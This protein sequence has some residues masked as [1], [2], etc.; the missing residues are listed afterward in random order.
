MLLLRGELCKGQRSLSSAE[1][2]I[3]LILF[4]VPQHS[5][6]DLIPNLDIP[7]FPSLYMY[8]ATKYAKVKSLDAGL[9]RDAGS[10]YRLRQ[11]LHLNIPWYTLSAAANSSLIIPLRLCNKLPNK[12][13]RAIKSFFFNKYF[14]SV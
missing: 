7:T 14:Y 11:T 4:K 3:R 6:K 8:H 2:I 12:F 10:R 9:T 13:N 1:K 5:C